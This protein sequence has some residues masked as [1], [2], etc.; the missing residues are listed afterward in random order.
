[1]RH[2]FG[3]ASAEKMNI[4][5]RDMK[6]RIDRKFKSDLKESCK[7][8]YHGLKIVGRPLCYVAMGNFYGFV[9]GHMPD[10]GYDYVPSRAS[11]RLL[12]GQQPWAIG[13]GYNRDERP[14]LATIESALT[15]PLTIHHII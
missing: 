10:G 13:P 4:M 11:G 14:F 3:Y 2:D 9:K 7:A 6:K 15:F 12:E 5:T 1:V 8:H